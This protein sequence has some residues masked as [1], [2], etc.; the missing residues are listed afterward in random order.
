MGQL[1]FN[2]LVSAIGIPVLFY[3]IYQWYQERKRKKEFELL[4]MR[5]FRRLQAVKDQAKEIDALIEEMG[6]KKIDYMTN[7]LKYK[8]EGEGQGDD[9]K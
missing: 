1:I 9:K 3:V 7:H 2:N 4:D 5:N 8:K 6:E